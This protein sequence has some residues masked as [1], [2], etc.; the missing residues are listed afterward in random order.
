MTP[1]PLPAGARGAGL[2]LQTAQLLFPPSPAWGGRLGWALGLRPGCG[3]EDTA[4]AGT[5]YVGATTGGERDPCAGAARGGW[6][7]A[8]LQFGRWEDPLD[9]PHSL[10]SG[11]FPASLRAR[12]REPL[13]SSHIGK[14]ENPV[15]RI[16]FLGLYLGCYWVAFLQ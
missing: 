8:Q 9:K 3:P 16:P 2:P 14:P 15:F 1:L 6:G 4:G 10:L 5:R 12:P 13:Q 11:R 7:E